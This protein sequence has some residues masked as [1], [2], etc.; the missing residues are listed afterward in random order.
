MH[1]KAHNLFAMGLSSIVGFFCALF[2][3]FGFFNF[4]IIVALS[5][6]IGMLSDIDLLFNIQHRGKTHKFPFIIVWTIIFILITYIITGYLQL[7]VGEN[8]LTGWSLNAEVNYFPLPNFTIQTIFQFVSMF[9]SLIVAGI[10]HLIL[11]EITTASLPG[12]FGNHYEGKIKSDNIIANVGFILLGAILLVVGISGHLFVITLQIIN[13]FWYIII[14]VSLSVLIFIIIISL[15][16]KK[17]K[18]I[19]EELFEGSIHGIPMVS[20]GNP[21][22]NIKGEDFCFD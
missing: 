21:C 15:I 14:S 20:V 22:I 5:G 10:T 11:D 1:S 13:P 3:H 2:L 6:I 4:I 9:I 12:T 8:D 16:R 17:D 7:Y 18:Y 19:P